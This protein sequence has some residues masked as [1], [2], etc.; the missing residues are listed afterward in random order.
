MVFN[1]ISQV[2]NK[3]IE[4]F[5]PSM[6]GSQAPSSWSVKP[7]HHSLLHVKATRCWDV[8]EIIGVTRQTY[9]SLMNKQPWNLTHKTTQSTLFP[10][11]TS[12]TEVS[13][14]NSFPSEPSLCNQSQKK[15]VFTLWTRKPSTRRVILFTRGLLVVS[16]LAASGQFKARG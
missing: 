2:I 16:V 8:T 5:R 6:D 12:L 11:C 13:M 15:Q 7:G 10:S 9:L 3:V 4:R 14:R 1:S